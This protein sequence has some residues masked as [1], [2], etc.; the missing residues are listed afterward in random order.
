MRGEMS[1]DDQSAEPE[2]EK[3]CGNCHHC[4]DIRWTEKITCLAYLDVRH[5]AKLGECPEFLRRRP[6]R[7]PQPVSM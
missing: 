7:P 1:G 2:D 5:Q 6:N 3:R 4:I